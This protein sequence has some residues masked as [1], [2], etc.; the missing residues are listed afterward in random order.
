MCH[1]NLEPKSTIDYLDIAFKLA[2]VCIALFNVYFASK[3]FRIKNQKD[4]SEKER[5]RKLQLLKTLVLDHNLKH[6]Y[7]GFSEIETKLN[8]LKTPNLSDENKGEIDSA[9]ADLFIKLRR[10]FYDSLLAIDNVLYE[11]IVNYSDELQGHLTDTIFDAGINLSH[12]PKFEE[13]INEKIIN[14]KTEIIKKLYNYRG[15]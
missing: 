13:L 15:N 14:T 6:Y 2:T 1:Y 12:K 11:T 7:S 4:D 8:E 9:V 3:V 5:D 10:R